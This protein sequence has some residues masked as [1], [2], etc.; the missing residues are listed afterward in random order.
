MKKHTILLVDDHALLRHGLAAILSYQK[1]LEVVGEASN[2][3]D[4]VHLAARLQ[5]EL[6]IMDLMMPVID[7]VEAT[8]QITE[9]TPNVKVLILT[10]FGTSADVSR[11]LDAGAAG[12]IMKDSRDEELLA[13]IHDT[14]AG[15]KVL[16]PDIAHMLKNEPPPPELTDRQLEILQSLTSGL[17]NKDIAEQ[18]GLRPSGV[19][20]HLKAIFAKLGAATRAEAVAIA[21]RKH[22]LKI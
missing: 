14:L 8:R 12:A 9:A 17:S 10:S 4:A 6:V 15:R 2:G 16:S 21:L 1:D 5:P 13:A 22:L 20:V 3:K 11:A 18:L 19:K 7:G